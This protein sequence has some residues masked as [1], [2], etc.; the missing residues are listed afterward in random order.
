MELEVKIRD[1]EQENK[2][3]K[4]R[5]IPIHVGMLASSQEIIKQEIRD[6]LHVTLENLRR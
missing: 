3:N 2:T 1:L 6:E 5:L 4:E